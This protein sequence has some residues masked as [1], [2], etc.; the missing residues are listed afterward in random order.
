MLVA[1]ELIGTQATPEPANA[2]QWAPAPRAPTV[3]SGCRLSGDRNALR[4]PPL[5]S[6]IRNS[7]SKPLPVPPML[8][9]LYLEFLTYPDS[10][11]SYVLNTDLEHI[12]LSS[13]TRFKS[14]VLN[15]DLEHIILS[16]VNTALP[17]RKCDREVTLAKSV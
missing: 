17:S 11:K 2:G 6:C 9:V 8:I 14:Y 16:S 1:G 3:G 13:S 7:C 5:R 10:F 4:S 15:T 12:I